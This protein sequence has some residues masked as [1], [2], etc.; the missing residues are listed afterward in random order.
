VQIDV[1]VI[2]RLAPS[3]EASQMAWSRMAK[4]WGELTSP[5]SRTDPALV[6]VNRRF[7]LL[8]LRTA[9]RR[10]APSDCPK[11][12]FMA[13]RTFG[14]I[15]QLPSGRWHARFR[16]RDGQQKSAPQT[17]LT[18]AD[19]GRW[20]PRTQADIERGEFVELQAPAPP[21]VGP[22]S[23]LGILAVPALLMFLAFAFIPLIG[24]LVLSFTDWDGI[25]AIEF[26][27][28]QSWVQVLTDPGTWHALWLTFALMIITW[29]VQ[30][31]ICLLL[32]TFIAGQQ[33]Y[34]AFLAVLF[35]LPLLLSS[36]AIAI[37]FSP[38]WTRTLDWPPAC[39][40]RAWH[41]TGWV[42]PRWRSSLWSS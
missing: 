20:L 28:G 35:F 30:T 33:R 41:R 34:R 9:G 18:K 26:V 24:V 42:I 8:R 17:F 3:L 14:T 37:A 40:C 13:R 10:G 31:P 7:Q 1:D 21:A 2:H 32:G 27:G 38:C 5:A 25:G 4:R 16:N 11:R 23:R 29:L 19:A 36:A 6:S 22:K 39:T 12:N 15:R